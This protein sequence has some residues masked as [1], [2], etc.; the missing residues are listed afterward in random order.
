VKQEGKNMTSCE[1]MLNKNPE[2]TEML[3]ALMDLDYTNP[4]T[5]SHMGFYFSLQMISVMFFHDMAKKK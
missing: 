1:T 4:Y 3:Y 2:F 5:R